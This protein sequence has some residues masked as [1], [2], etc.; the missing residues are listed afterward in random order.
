MLFSLNLDPQALDGEGRI[1]LDAVRNAIQDYGVLAMSRDDIF[2]F[3]AWMQKQFPTEWVRWQ[4]TLTRIPQALQADRVSTLLPDERKLIGS[5]DTLY[6]LHDGLARMWFTEHP[7][8]P[9]DGA[10]LVS[11]C[12]R[13]FVEIAEAG[14]FFSTKTMRSRQTWASSALLKTDSREELWH[15]LRPL[16]DIFEHSFLV[17]RYALINGFKGFDNPQRWRTANGLAWLMEK[18]SALEPRPNRVITIAGWPAE[19]PNNSKDRYQ[20]LGDWLRELT[21]GKISKVTLLP[22]PKQVPDF[23]LNHDR[24]MRFWNSKACKFVEVGNSLDEFRYKSLS[25]DVTFSYRDLQ[26][27]DSNAR[28]ICEAQIREAAAPYLTHS[29]SG[30]G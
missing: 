26:S 14:A 2:A 3:R 4:E 11:E 1:G 8:N 22:A 21:R 29:L 16:F 17:D 30:S 6:L 25:Q 23:K 24:S 12:K 28:E 7:Q 19:T 15:R 27:N 18:M 5:I 20:I 9:V 13:S 10:L